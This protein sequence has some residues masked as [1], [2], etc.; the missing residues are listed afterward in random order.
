[1]SEMARNYDRPNYDRP[2]CMCGPRDKEGM[3]HSGA[4]RQA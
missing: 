3:T 4:T 1:M 2:N